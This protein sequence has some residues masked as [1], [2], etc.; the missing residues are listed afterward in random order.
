MSDEKL[1]RFRCWKCKFEWVSKSG[2]CVCPR[3]EH[4]Y[5]DWLN[6]KESV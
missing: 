5:I 3:C 6:Y 4:E 1:A 2:P